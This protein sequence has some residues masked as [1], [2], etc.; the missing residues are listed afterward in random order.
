LCAP[1]SI[2]RPFAGRH[3]SAHPLDA[4]AQGSAAN[5]FATFGSMVVN[6]YGATLAAFASEYAK[7]AAELKNV[8]LPALGLPTSPIA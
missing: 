8:D 4:H 1:S 5:A 3:V 7:A 6:G 2:T